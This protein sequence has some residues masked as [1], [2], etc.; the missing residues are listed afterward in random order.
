MKPT[1]SLSA[2]RVWLL[3]LAVTDVTSIKV[4]A[5]YIFN[6]LMMQKKFIRL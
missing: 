4:L 1:L 2:V 6:N 5:V 3:R